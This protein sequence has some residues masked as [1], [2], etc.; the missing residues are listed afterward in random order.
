MILDTLK[1]RLYQK[2]EK[3]PGR[4][5]KELPA[6]VWGLRTQASRSTGVSPYFLVYGSEAIL[7]AD[8]AFRAPRVENFVEEQATTVWTED[9]DWAKEERLITC[10]RTAKYLEDLRRYY[11]HNVKGRSFTVGDLVL[12]RK[13][14]TKGMNKLSSPWE[15][16]YMVKEVTRPG[17]YR[18][19]DMEGIDIPKSWHIEYII[20]F[21]P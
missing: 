12:R 17:S 2:E 1:K 15:G 7:P 3:H 9:I 11:N 8:V 4:W 14:K 20:R 6:V 21:Y 13:Q 10:V 16:P 19:C 18:L 5:L